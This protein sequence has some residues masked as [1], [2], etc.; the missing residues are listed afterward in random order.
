VTLDSTLISD[1]GVGLA[2]I[3]GGAARLSNVNV[4]GNALG[5]DTAAGTVNSFGNN[6]TTS[7]GGAQPTVDN[8]LSPL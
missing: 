5:F 8:H 7:N 3:S 1:S 4:V 6:H 2:L